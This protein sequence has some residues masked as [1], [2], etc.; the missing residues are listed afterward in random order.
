VKQVP[1]VH[2]GPRRVD[3]YRVQQLLVPRAR[4]RKIRAR[5]AGWRQ[6]REKNG[7]YK[8]VLLFGD[9]ETPKTHG[10]RTL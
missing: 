8:S 1:R 9:F 10:C 2:G 5:H 3:A 7:N 6:K 4:R